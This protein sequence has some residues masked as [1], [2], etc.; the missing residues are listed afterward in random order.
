MSLLAPGRAG[1]FSRES[2][3][4]AQLE[5][6][7]ANIPLLVAIFVTTAAIP[8]AAALLLPSE[9]RGLVVGAGLANAVWTTYWFVVSGSGSAPRMKGADAA[10]WTSDDLK[11]LR[12][13]GLRHIDELSLDGRSDVDHV[14]YGP[15]GVYA[16]ETKWSAS[17][18]F[19]RGNRPTSYLLSAVAQASRGAAKLRDRLAGVPQGVDTR[20]S[21]VLVLW[22]KHAPDTERVIEGV[23]VIGG[24]QLGA[25][26]ERQTG[27]LDELTV[28]R[29]GDAL[30]QL[31]RDSEAARRSGSR[32]V[33]GGFLGIATDVFLGLLAGVAAMLL[34][35]SVWGVVA[36]PVY[37]LIAG[38][39]VSA[40]LGALSILRRRRVLAVGWTVGTVGVLLLL[41]IAAGADIVLS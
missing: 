18:W 19:D 36:L 26:F 5:L 15:S 22:G 32:F 35:A 9:I 1:R 6:A 25:F 11:P 2:A 20:V 10:R 38:V 7:R 29:L 16:I 27:T 3:R 30:A 39:S 40:G 31:E 24:A 34:L 21:A 8:L 4:T 41:A 14:A 17:R 12:K 37:V 33:T 28:D 13:L 23:A